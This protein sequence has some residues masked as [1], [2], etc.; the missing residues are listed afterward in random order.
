M[1]LA[2]VNLVL[3]QVAIQV[4]LPA[5]ALVMAQYKVPLALFEEAGQPRGWQGAFP[6][7][8]SHPPPMEFEKHYNRK[9]VGLLWALRHQFRS[10]SPQR[11]RAGP[12][13]STVQG[14]SG[15]GISPG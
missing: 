13:F 8:G 1:G 7:S 12:G 3:V 6:Q 10:Q 14:H 15:R 4:Q 11:C 5:L 9:A 2:R